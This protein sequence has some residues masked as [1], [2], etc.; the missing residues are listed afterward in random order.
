MHVM[1]DRGYQQQVNAKTYGINVLYLVGM[2]NSVQEVQRNSVHRLIK[3][4]LNVQAACQTE[5][6]KNIEFLSTTSKI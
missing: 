2:R 5:T 4:A 3:T 1:T 6:T